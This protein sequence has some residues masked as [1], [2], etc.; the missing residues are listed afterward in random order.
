MILVDV[1]DAYT[2][3]VYPLTNNGELS[4]NTM[5]KIE[6]TYIG[7][8][9]RSSQDTNMLYHFLMYLLSKFGKATVCNIQY[10]F[11]VLPSVNLLPKVIIR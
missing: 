8:E 10:K 2:D 7:K 1:S 6:E 5:K 11:N 9:S 4:V 3:Y